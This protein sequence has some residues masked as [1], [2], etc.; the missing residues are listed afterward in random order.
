VS[1]TRKIK[2]R[3]AS[4]Q[5]LPRCADCHSTTTIA[6]IG[7]DGPVVIHTEHQPSCP[8]LCGTVPSVFE[9]WAKAEA[10]T[11]R[12]VLYLRDRV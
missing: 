9:R 5:E 3:G 1:N 6:V 7:E 12:P 2:L 4:G 11:E 10:A 8:V